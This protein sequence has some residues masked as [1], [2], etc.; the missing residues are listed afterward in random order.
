M[1]ISIKKRHAEWIAAQ[2]SAGR[3]TSETEAID[4]AI[5]TKIEED[6]IKRLRERLKESIAQADRGETVLA[7]DAFWESKRQMVRDRYMNPET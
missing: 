3:Y 6:E 7:D 2:V 5:A 1:N 4:D